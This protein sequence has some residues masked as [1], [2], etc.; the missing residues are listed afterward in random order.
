MIQFSIVTREFRG[1]VDRRAELFTFLGSAYAAMGLFLLNVL[2]GGLPPSLASIERNL[3][4]CYSF[5]LMVI[6]SILALRMAWLHKGMV[7]NVILYAHFMQR[8]T[9]TDSAREPTPE[10]AA[11]TRLLSVSFLQSFQAA[12][13][14]GISAAVFCLAI[15]ITIGPAILIGVIGI[16]CWWIFYT[17]E[18]R[19]GLKVASELVAEGLGPVTDEQWRDHQSECLQQSSQG[20]LYEIGFAGLI[21][22]SGFEALSGLGQIKTH[23]TIDVPPSD[24]IKH[25]PKVFGVL[26]ATCCLLQL[27]VYLRVRIAVGRFSMALNPNDRPNSPWRLM[28][29]S[30]LG[31]LLIAFLFGISI[32]VLVT[33]FFEE[34]SFWKVITID[35]IAVA[36]AILL[37]RCFLYYHDHPAHKSTSS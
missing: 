23:E 17:W 19:R 22:F 33:V 2:Q 29:D 37:E 3:F 10:S 21:V 9:F 25:G 7:I 18:H 26:M 12:L 24:V 27:L 20:L 11:R 28:T 36:L 34:L 14:A 30:S 6:V 32:H 8:Q 4:A 15:G 1:L 13:I 31:Y 16:G 5:V 35:L